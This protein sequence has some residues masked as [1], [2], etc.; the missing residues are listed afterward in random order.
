MGD[1]SCIRDD[2]Y[3]EDLFAGYEAVALED[4]QKIPTKEHLSQ[5]ST[6]KIRKPAAGKELK[7]FTMVGQIS[8]GG[9]SILLYKQIELPESVFKNTYRLA[10]L[11]NNIAQVSDINK[12]DITDPYHSFYVPVKSLY[13]VGGAGGGRKSRRRKGKGSKRRSGLRKRN[14]SKR[15]TSRQK[16]LRKSRRKSSSGN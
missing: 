3:I 16:L 11:D 14:G 12:T 6:V 4:G 5:I 13:L 1:D 8:E 15:R 10:S 7:I 2:S 9:K